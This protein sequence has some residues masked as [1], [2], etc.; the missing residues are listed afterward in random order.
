MT[1]TRNEEWGQAALVDEREQIGSPHLGFPLIQRDNDECPPFT[2]PTRRASGGAATTST[3]RYLRT[4]A[5]VA[6]LR[7]RTREHS[8]LLPDSDAGPRQRSSARV[9]LEP[10]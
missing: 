5:R 2:A 3:R 10:R 7:R 9:A 6:T 1:T 8:P 4:P